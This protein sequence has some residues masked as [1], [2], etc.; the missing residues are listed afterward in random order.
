MQI[1]LYIIAAALVFHVA[2]EIFG[3]VRQLHRDRLM[4][5]LSAQQQQIIDQ[6]NE[7]DERVERNIRILLIASGCSPERAD[8]L[9]GKSP[10]EILSLVQ[11]EN[12]PHE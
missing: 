6:Q 12:L 11:E 7:S 8:E 3:T 5:V 1:P 4:V 10:A 9:L 2:L